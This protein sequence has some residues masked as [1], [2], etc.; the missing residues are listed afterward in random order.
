MIDLHIHTTHSD[1][2]DSTEELLK[3]AENKKLEIISIT[4]HDC[5]DA[6]LE[7]EKNPE[8]RKNFSGKIIVGAELKTYFD[9]VPVEVLA[10]G[11]NYKALRIHK[12]NMD[13]LQK[14][15]L[16]E[17]KARA[18]K[19]GLIFDEENMY[20]DRNDPT[21]QF[22]GFTFATEILKHKENEQII[23]RNW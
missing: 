4:D 3:N 19:I 14:E 9:G 15:T 17:L 22:A 13:K 23:S 6:Y 16:E 10:Y 21:K 1:G 18:K 7:L 8:I 5:I 11:V 20:I 2:T 12:I